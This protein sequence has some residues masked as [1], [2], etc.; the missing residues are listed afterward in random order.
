[1]D[2]ENREGRR[3]RITDIISLYIFVFKYMKKIFNII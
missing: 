1:M 3:E 2:S